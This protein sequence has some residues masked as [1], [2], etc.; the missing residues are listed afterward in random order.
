MRE[1]IVGELT[2]AA[3]EIFRD[4]AHL[5]PRLIVMLII[6]F[7]GWLIAYVVRAVLRSVLRFAKFDKLFEKQGRRNC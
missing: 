7:V 4:F 1:I 3:Q 6:V 2:K 5:L